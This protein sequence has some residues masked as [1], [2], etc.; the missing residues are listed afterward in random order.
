MLHCDLQVR[1]Q[2]TEAPFLGIKET[3]YCQLRTQVWL[4]QLLFLALCSIHILV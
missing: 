4:C 2:E 1:L 3:S